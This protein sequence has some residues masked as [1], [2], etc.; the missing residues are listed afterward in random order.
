MDL[1]EFSVNSTNVFPMA[2]SHAGGQLM[3]EYNLRSRE[4]VETTPAV[5]Y[6]IGPS[7]THSLNDFKIGQATGSTFTISAGRALVNGYYVES[8]VPIDIDIAEC[9]HRIAQEPDLNISELKGNLTV[10]LKIRFSTEQTIIG[11]AESEIS[12]NAD[13]Y[14][15]MYGGICVVILPTSEFILPEDSPTDESRVTAHLK[16]GTLKY[17]SGEISNVVENTA[18]IQSVPAERLGSLEGIISDEYISREGL[19]PGKMYVISSQ[20]DSNSGL[21]TWCQADESLLIWTTPREKQDQPDTGYNQAT[22][23]YVPFDDAIH[24]TVPRKQIDGGSGGYYPNVDLKLP[25][26]NFADNIGG[27]V[28]RAFMGKIR[29]IEAQVNARITLPEGYVVK[30]FDVF[31][32][33][34]ELPD[35]TD[36]HEGDAVLVSQDYTVG[37]ADGM[38]PSTMYM[39]L[40]QDG[41]KIW[42]DAVI[43][44]RQISY[45]TEDMVGGFLNVPEDTIGG[46]Y[47]YLDNTGHLRVL[48][49]E[50]LAS[51]VLAY[52]LGNDLTISGDSVEEVQSALNNLVCERV[53]F[54]D[55]SKMGDE[56]AAMINVVITLPDY[57]STKATV[58]TINVYGIDSR[59][60]TAVNLQFVTAD[61]ATVS[62]QLVVNIIGCEKVKLS[63]SEDCNATFNLYRS[64]LYYDAS[65]LNQL[66]AIQGLGLWYERYGDTDQDLTVN[67]LTVER[68]GSITVSSTHEWWDANLAPN[69]NHLDWAVKSITFTST[70]KIDSCDLL[71]MDN[72][73]GSA[74]TGQ[75][76]TFSEFKLSSSSGQFVIPVR[77]L[78]DPI[79]ICGSFVSAYQV[80]NDPVTYQM[81]NISFT[82]CSGVNNNGAETAGQIAFQNTIS[83]C[84][85]IVGPEGQTLTA[86]Q[87]QRWHRFHGGT[88]T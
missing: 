47:V 7:Y 74:A 32:E 65:I 76:V 71:V 33:N 2:N 88:P 43:L 16:L 72:I 79:R 31:D 53:A 83:D 84:S 19:D 44:T 8:L 45:A 78:I 29:D 23:H 87:T 36:L 61:G 20:T 64:N 54:P 62:S 69:D 4:S 11:T 70:G 42:T 58:G 12:N 38:Y 13:P 40:I 9:N 73:T 35:L 18:R 10:G 48:D 80:E 34:S 39:V 49:Y 5:Q 17:T 51:G 66:T 28:T 22:F 55:A 46:G 86:F 26:C 37:G 3:T 15:G 67:G 85:S 52:Q 77:K 57:P 56:N 25:P 41:E 1:L 6:S 14:Y 82:A 30:Y 75:F 59:F 50:L 24:L 63:I 21:P 60:G 81:H 27:T 68:E